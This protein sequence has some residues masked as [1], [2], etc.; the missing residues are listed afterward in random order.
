MNAEGVL[1]VGATTRFESSH[2]LVLHK[3]VLQ[4]CGS[5]AD[6]YIVHSVNGMRWDV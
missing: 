4:G 3:E 5:G 6:T 1:I 2:L